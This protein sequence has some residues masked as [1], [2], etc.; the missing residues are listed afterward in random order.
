MANVT[1]NYLSGFNNYYNR[2]VKLPQST[3]VSDYE[4]WTVFTTKPTSFNPNDNV[5]TTIVVN[6]SQ[7]DLDDTVELDYVIVSEDNINVASR[8]FVLDR[9]RNLSGQWTLKLRRDLISDHYQSVVTSPMF[10]EKAH[11]N[12][13]YNPLIFNKETGMGYNQIKKREELLQDE[14]KSGWIVGYIANNATEVEVSVSSAD[15]NYPAPPID[16][17]TLRRLSTEGCWR[18]STSSGYPLY[19]IVGNKTT[20]EAYYNWSLNFYNNGGVATTSSTVT[21]YPSYLLNFSK[22]GT[23][24]QAA[25]NLSTQIAQRQANLVWQT[26][27]YAQTQIGGNY[28]ADNELAT[29]QAMSGGT[30]TDEG[31]QTFKFTFRTSYQRNHVWTINS[32]AGQLYNTF[33]DAWDNANVGTR[34]TYDNTGITVYFSQQVYTLIIEDVAPGATVT[35]PTS[36]NSLNDAPYKMFCIPND[37]VLVETTSQSFVNQPNVA[38]R[39]AANLAVKYGSFLYD[40]QLLPY[41]PFRSIVNKDDGTIETATLG[42]T[43]ATVVNLDDNQPASVILWPT[44]SNFNFTISTV[45][46]NCPT[47]SVE[48]KVDHETKFIRLCSPNYSG[49]FE[50][51]PTS[52]YGIQGF[53]IN[54]TYKPF[55][56][57]IHVCPLFNENGLYG[58]DYNDQR[59][60]VCT[61]DFSLPLVT[62]NW[63]QYQINN[64]SYEDSFN[65]QI[66]NMETTYQLNRRQATTAGIANVVTSAI[67]GATSGGLVGSVGGGLGAGIGAGIGAVAGGIASGV[68]LAA[69]LQHME[70]MQREAKSYAED[71]YGYNL[72]NIQALPY[73]LGKVSAFSIN[74]KVFPFLEF[75]TA[76]TEEENALRFKLTYNGFTVM[77]GS[78]ISSYSSGSGDNWIQGQL[79]RYIGEDMDYH[80][81]TELASELHKGVYI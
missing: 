14:T 18:A 77:V 29:L 76:T 51:K 69:D 74:N 78:A 42:E 70:A 68:G 50:F 11:I 16:L 31:G 63:I 56:P 55:S 61:G 72:Q 57:Y 45:A 26:K 36:V 8:W 39:V 67:S 7:V 4:E 35:V 80:E 62:D 41:C 73:T 60:L 79:V 58:G 81:A 2:Q 1:L 49:S 21:N 75:Y 33:I 12:N 28:L 47:D 52:N 46:V 48:F 25:A 13:I 9:S 71:M 27:E 59:G 10:I 19:R 34:T 23:I 17:E 65:R 30:Y 64:K 5:N 32:S 53:E 15:Q 37:E 3:L 24:D 66:E 44:S 54:C 38:R 20:S 40:L 6:Y 43:S 22:V